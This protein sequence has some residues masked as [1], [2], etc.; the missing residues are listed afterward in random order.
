MKEE[1]IADLLQRYMEAETTAPEEERLRRYFQSGA[2][3]ARWAAYAPLFTAVPPEG[4]A[5]TD[6]ECDEILSLCPAPST[7]RLVRHNWWRYTAVWMGGLLIGGGGMW[8]ASGH[9]GQS[10]AMEGA[11]AVRSSV[12]DTLYCERVVTRRDT[13]YIVQIQS[14]P[15]SRPTPS[16]CQPHPTAQLTVPPTPQYDPAVPRTAPAQEEPQREVPATVP[17]VPWMETGNM[18]NLAVR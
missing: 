5:L 1:E 9:T 16:A 18:A 3:E 2:Y 15:A 4:G 11:Q 13:V 6:A 12:V 14:A 7:A 10:D 17:E 8:L